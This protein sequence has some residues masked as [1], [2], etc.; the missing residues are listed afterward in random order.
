MNGQNLGKSRQ[1]EMQIRLPGFMTS[2]TI[3]ATNLFCFSKESTV[4][5]DFV[6]LAE[7]CKIQF[8]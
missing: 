5:S 7:Y 6:K 8:L 4:F 1:M 2:Q 3:L